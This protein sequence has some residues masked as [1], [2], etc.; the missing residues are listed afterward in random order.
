MVSANHYSRE[1][2]VILLR[3]DALHNLHCL[4]ITGMSYSVGFNHLT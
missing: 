1:W 2:S 3:Q 4:N